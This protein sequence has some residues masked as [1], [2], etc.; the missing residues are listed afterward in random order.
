MPVLAT[1]LVVVLG[2]A[3]WVTVSVVNRKAACEQPVNVLVTASADIAP[4]LTIVARGLDLPCG[5]VEVQTREATQAAERLALSDG[6]PRPQV[7]VP[8]STLA[9]R[10][11]HQLGAADVP[12]TGASVASS[13][14]VLGVA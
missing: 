1:G 5:A 7:W 4:A 3:A 10:R 9:L 11:A 13:P 14:V 12:E 6:S 8:D 2:A